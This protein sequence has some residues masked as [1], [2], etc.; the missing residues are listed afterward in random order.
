M[1]LAV[2][3]AGAPAIRTFVMIFAV[4]EGDSCPNSLKIERAR[5]MDRHLAS[6]T[7]K[8]NRSGISEPTTRIMRGVLGASAFSPSKP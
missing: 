4:R 5:W 7:I 6:C 2:I 8:E 3:I 1:G